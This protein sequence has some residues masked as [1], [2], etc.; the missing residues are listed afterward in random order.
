MEKIIK[1]AKEHRPFFHLS[2]DVDRILENEFSIP[3]KM[4]E[5]GIFEGKFG[6]ELN[7]EKFLKPF[8]IV[9]RRSRDVAGVFIR[10]FAV[11]LGKHEVCHI[12]YPKNDQQIKSLKAKIDDRKTFVNNS[13]SVHFQHPTIPANSFCI[14][15]KRLQK[16]LEGDYGLGE[17]NIT[18]S[19]CE[20]FAHLMVLGVNYSEQVF[21]F[22]PE[23]IPCQVKINVFLDQPKLRELT[24]QEKEV[25][26]YLKNETKHFQNFTD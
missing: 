25:V 15:V 9:C 12:Y 11:Y 3:K 14:M 7:P 5:N 19:N 23:E 1:R 4:L 6:S 24:L 16:S 10:H 20:H 2:E 22:L 13:K 18:E 26:E 21:K 17:Y 8:D